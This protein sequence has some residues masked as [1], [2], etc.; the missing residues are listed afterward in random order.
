MPGLAAGPEIFEY[1]EF[2]SKQYELHFLKWLKPLS[3]EETI[4]NYAM[5]LTLNISHKNI[6]LVGV[7]FGGIIVQEMS[8]YVDYKKIIL[9][10][11]VKSHKEFPKRFKIASVSKLY[12]LFPTKMVSNFEDYK[13][14]FLG[15]SLKKRAKIYEK[16]L[17]ERD[18]DYLKW[19]IYNVLHWNQN[20]PPLNTIHIHGTK[21]I[22]FPIKN[23]FDVIEI[24]GGTHV[25][26]I[27][28]A[29]LLS[30][31][32]HHNLIN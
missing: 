12:K 26:I 17:H 25:M 27:N 21:D 24:E 5:R 1:L 16:Y 20:S 13:K 28:K 7:S 19:S 10:S 4:E 14:F 22:V 18:E 6:V 11:S 31:I 29:K 9:I 3:I 15:K 30:K 8:K 23:I 32:I 2:D